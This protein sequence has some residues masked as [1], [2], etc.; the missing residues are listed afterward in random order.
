VSREARPATRT[1]GDETGSDLGRV[2]ALS[3]GVFA[4]ALTVLVLELALPAATTEDT[5]GSALRDLGPKYFAYVLTFV[6]IGTMWLIHRLMFRRIVRTNST[7]LILNLLLLLAVT[8]QPFPT[9]VLGQFGGTT[10]ATVFYACSV[11]AT[12]C[13]STGMW[14]YISGPRGLLDLTTDPRWIHTGRVRTLAGTAMFLLS[15]PVAVVAP[16]V[17]VVMWFLTFPIRMAIPRLLG[18]PGDELG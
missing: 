12:S 1:E 15:I 14:W 4:I 3:D 9:A 5:L 8:F 10:T 6:T 13:I 2:L 16:T 17:A 18:R 7:L 11:S